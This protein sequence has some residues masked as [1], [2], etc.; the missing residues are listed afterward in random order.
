MGIRPFNCLF[1]GPSGSGKTFAAS[2]LCKKIGYPAVL[3]NGHP[4]AYKK[5]NCTVHTVD[6]EEVP[7]TGKKNLCYIVEDIISLNKQQKEKLC[8]ILNYVSRH[9]DSCC[10]LICHAVF[11]TGIFSLL[12]F[13]TDYFFTGDPV[14]IREVRFLSKYFSGRESETMET[15]F[16]KLGPKEY[17][18]YIPNEDKCVHLGSKLRPLQSENKKTSSGSLNKEEV[19]RFFEHLPEKKQ[20]AVLLDFLLRVIPPAC[21]RKDDYSISYRGK[22]GIRNFSLL[23]Y[24]HFAMNKNVRPPADIRIFQRF[25]NKSCAFP[26]FI[27]LNQYMK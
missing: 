19:L 7:L 12:N 16:K 6:W 18:H 21:I 20:Y 23:D 2:L 10:L 11:R 22:R 3:L 1:I 25:L 15:M 9:H 4:S 17:L 14:N 26:R 24:L 27:I 13:I 5:D 8:L